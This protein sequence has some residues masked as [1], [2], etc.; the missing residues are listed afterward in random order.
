MKSEPRRI[1]RTTPVARRRRSECRGLVELVGEG[2][3]GCRRTPQSS[4]ESRVLG[5]AARSAGL[6]GSRVLLWVRP[7][8]RHS[9][10]GCGGARLGSAAVGR[11]SRTRQAVGG[12]GCT[13]GGW[14]AGL[15]VGT[16]GCARRRRLD[17]CYWCSR[18]RE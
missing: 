6:L 15:G 1:S 18:P 9:V 11:R 4:P 13:R 3:K 14:G 12:G 16:A 8:H 5:V 7:G 10:R 17:L 2:D